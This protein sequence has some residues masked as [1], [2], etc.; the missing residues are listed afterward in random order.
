[1]TGWERWAVE[2]QWKWNIVEFKCH[3]QDIYLNK[4]SLLSSLSPSMS[5]IDGKIMCFESVSIRNNLHFR[6]PKRSLVRSHELI[7]EGERSGE[8][9]PATEDEKDKETGCVSYDCCLHSA[10]LFIRCLS[11]LRT[12]LSMKNISLDIVNRV[13]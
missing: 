8:R 5:F 12:D 1:M 11:V 13:L 6:S 4:L 3:R 2:N 7:K 10:S 9:F